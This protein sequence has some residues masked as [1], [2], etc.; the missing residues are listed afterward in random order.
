MKYSILILTL[1]LLSF[2]SCKSD[3]DS[4]TDVDPNPII[5]TPARISLTNPE[6]GQMNRYVAFYAKSFFDT[7]TYQNDTILEVEIIDFSNEKLILEERRINLQP[8]EQVFDSRQT[9]FT[10][11]GG[12]LIHDSCENEESSFLILNESLN[13]FS[14]DSL[15]LQFENDIWPEDVF[16]NFI[17]DHTTNISI[18]DRSYDYL[19]LKID[20][21]ACLDYE[22]GPAEYNFVRTFYTAEDFVV[23]CAYGNT[24]S[25]GWNAN[26]WD[27]LVE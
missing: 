20:I 9:Y 1:S 13:L 7:I 12:R 15:L 19:Q 5:E 8:S 11:S 17:G 23:R 25:W 14:V 16:F 18:L 24:S 10:L 4:G 27:L 3:D 2:F 22:G 26:G 21:D 6:V